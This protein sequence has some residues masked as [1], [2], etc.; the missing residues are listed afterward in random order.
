MES[1][2]ARHMASGPQTSAP[3]I[4]VGLTLQPRAPRSTEQ[5]ARLLGWGQVSRPVTCAL[6]LRGVL[7][8]G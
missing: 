2:R 3:R 8:I 4:P 5:A 6:C 7:A 1:T